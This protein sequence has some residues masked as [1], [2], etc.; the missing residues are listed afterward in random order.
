MEQYLNL[1]DD[2]EAQPNLDL[3]LKSFFDFSQDSSINQDPS[4]VGPNNTAYSEQVFPEF[5]F[6]TESSGKEFQF[7]SIA[8]LLQ[9]TPM[10]RDLDYSTATETSTPHFT[11]MADNF[12][13]SN[14][15][16]DEIAALPNTNEQITISN[17]N[18]NK[19]NL[20]HFSVGQSMLCFNNDIF[21]GRRES[22]VSD[23]VTPISSN[24]NSPR[25]NSVNNNKI[26]RINNMRAQKPNNVRFSFNHVNSSPFA[27]GSSSSIAEVSMDSMFPPSPTKT[28]TKM[29]PKTKRRK[30]SSSSSSSVSSLTQDLLSMK[31]RRCIFKPAPK[32]KSELYLRPERRCPKFEFGIRSED[33]VINVTFQGGFIRNTIMDWYFP[34]DS[35]LPSNFQDVT[36]EYDHDYYAKMLNHINTQIA[37][38]NDPNISSFR[39]YWKILK[40]QTGP[41]IKLQ[42]ISETLDCDVNFS[43]TQYYFNIVSRIVRPKSFGP[44]ESGARYRAKMVND[45]KSDDS[46][47]KP[48]W[49]HFI[50]SAEMKGILDF[51]FDGLDYIANDDTLP[52]KL[53]K[54]IKPNPFKQH[55]SR[56]RSHMVGYV[57]G[58]KCMKDAKNVLTGERKVF[59]EEMYKQVIG[60]DDKRRPYNTLKEFA[61]MEVKYMMDNI[62]DLFGK[63]YWVDPGTVP[64]GGYKVRF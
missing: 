38:Q 27:V 50:T 57:S 9:D 60:Y 14:Y 3:E 64:T 37:M 15:S 59:A 33:N 23:T 11:Y 62:E 35:A 52:D 6:E 8:E 39:T 26:N 56:I 32:K 10:S 41:H 4:A 29:L 63:F 18:N 36:I 17:T 61:V 31:D 21:D 20:M 46:T 40:C 42:F 25:S 44:I 28:P 53:S 16:L 34:S 19:G 12:L 43:N 51:I 48:R 30:S 7:G 2:G 55:E 22:F 49:C 47:G 5:T 45:M 58:K 1:S 24:T 54:G 13:A